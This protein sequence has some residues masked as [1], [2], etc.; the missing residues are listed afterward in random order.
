ME[1]W[2]Q[3]TRRIIILFFTVVE[4]RSEK[5]LIPIILKH[6]RPGSTIIPDYWK[7]YS[8]LKDYGYNHMTV[9]HSKAFKDQ[10]TGAHI[11]NIE[12][13]WALFTNDVSKEGGVAKN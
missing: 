4:K 11:N 3:R 8:K 2:R 7:S 9:N 12:C 10:E 1:V 6:I 13:S 5:I